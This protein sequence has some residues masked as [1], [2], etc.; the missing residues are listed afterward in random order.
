MKKIIILTLLIANIYLILG[1]NFNQNKEIIAEQRIGEL[2]RIVLINTSSE[3]SAQSAGQEALPNA[4]VPSHKYGVLQELITTPVESSCAFTLS[5]ITQNNEKRN[6]V[7][8]FII[9]KFS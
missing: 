8:F 3:P 7:T 2:S 5:E 9:K 4:A 1:C 6:N